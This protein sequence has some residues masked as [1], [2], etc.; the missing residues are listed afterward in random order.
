MQLLICPV[1]GRLKGK[2]EVLSVFAVLEV[3]LNFRLSVIAQYN[4]GIAPVVSICKKK[5]SSEVTVNQFLQ[6]ISIEK[7]SK[8]WSI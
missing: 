8:N 5:G 7:I 3:S 1:I 4:L 2:G 6:C